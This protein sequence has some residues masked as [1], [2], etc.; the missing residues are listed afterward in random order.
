MALPSLVKTWQFTYVNQA[1]A[2]QGS[3]LL[4]NRRLFRSIKNA[5]I[6]FASTPWTVRYSCNGTVPGTG[7]A[8]DG[9][10]RWAAD[11]DLVWAA[12]GNNHSW[13]V[14]QQA[15]I[16]AGFQICIDL[17]SSVAYQGS[18]IVSPSAGFTGGTTTARPT[19]TDEIAV[20]SAAQ[21]TLHSSDVA[22]KW[23]VIQSTDG[24]CTR[25]AVFSAGALQAYASFEKPKNPVTGWSNPS[26]SM[27]NGGTS[28]MA[29]L[30]N[31]S[32][33]GTTSSGKFRM[34]ATN[35]NLFVASEGHSTGQLS[36][37]LSGANAAS[38][39]FPMFPAAMASVTATIQGR[40]GEFF[41]LWAAQ[42][43][44]AS[45]DGYPASGTTNQFVNVG[46]LIWPWNGSSAIQLT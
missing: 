26:W 31:I 9:V 35:G 5:L 27:W 30:A 11:T 6:G 14:L 7:V 45:G 15:G 28:N 10:D 21:F 23:H 41:D 17:N 4:L 46:Q 43:G 20:I 16:N 42:T 1:I 37:L 36:S 22:L 32:S 3:V 2:T 24:Q 29:N 25:I 33:S 39:E 18:I 12:S 44:T 8:G 34:S 40:H 13:M 38:A 19:A